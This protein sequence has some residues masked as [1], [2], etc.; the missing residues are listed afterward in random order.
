MGPGRRVAEAAG[1]EV[2]KFRAVDTVS[3]TDSGELECGEGW[4]SARRARGG[5]E[6][7]PLTNSMATRS[8]APTSC[9][10]GSVIDESKQLYYAT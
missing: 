1:V 5:G 4:E 2:S 10:T 9:A 7:V 8:S 6:I 3:R